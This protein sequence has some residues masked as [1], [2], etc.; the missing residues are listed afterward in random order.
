M[1]IPRS[2]F[3]ITEQSRFL[4]KLPRPKEYFASSKLT[5]FSEC[6]DKWLM[7]HVYQKDSQK[8]DPPSPS[9]V[10]REWIQTRTSGNSMALMSSTAATQK[11]KRSRDRAEYFSSGKVVSVHQREKSLGAES[12]EMG[13]QPCVQS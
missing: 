7:I 8:T 1:E 3:F 4:R 6:N 12:K 13:H 11:K 9:E 2:E 10:F 5:V